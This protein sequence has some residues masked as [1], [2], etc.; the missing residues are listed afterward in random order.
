MIGKLKSI[1]IISLIIYAVFQH[2]HIQS[3]EEATPISPLEEGIEVQIEVQIAEKDER[4]EI[5][6]AFF[7]NYQSPLAENAATFVKV[8]DQ[9]GLEWTLLPAIASQESAFGKRTPSCAPYNPFGWTSITSPCGFWRFADFN[10]AIRHVAE[11]ISNLPHYADFRRT[12]EMQDL[13]KKYNG[14]NPE[15]WVRKVLFFRKKLWDFQPAVDCSEQEQVIEELIER[16][17]KRIRANELEKLK[18]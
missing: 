12:G 3:L 8:A 10:Y 7:T 14:G 1:L 18:K 2:R 13:A 15:E 5:L 9:Y 4:V 6:E 17:Y 11:S 16:D